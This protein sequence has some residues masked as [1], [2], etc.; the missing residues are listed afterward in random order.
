MY[1][2]PAHMPPHDYKFEFDEHKS[3]VNRDKHSIDFEE[4]QRLWL[5][6]T[7]VEIPARSDG[8]SRWLVIGMIDKQFWAAVVTYRGDRIRIISVRHARNEEIAIYENR[9]I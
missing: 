1:F 6:E 7:L 3:T 9:G 5:D 2:R 8:E 4:A